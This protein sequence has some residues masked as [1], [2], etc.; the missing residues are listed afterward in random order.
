MLETN[1]DI[2]ETQVIIANES[3][4]NPLLFSLEGHKSE[5]RK[6]SAKKGKYIPQVLFQ[7]CIQKVKRNVEKENFLQIVALREKPPRKLHYTQ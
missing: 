3:E 7:S 6:S 4:N 2:Q 1:Q 5:E